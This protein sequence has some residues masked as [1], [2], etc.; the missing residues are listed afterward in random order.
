MG[1]VGLMFG[2]IWFENVLLEIAMYESI[3]FPFTWQLSGF[4]NLEKWAGLQ[5]SSVPLI[6][7][8][9]KIRETKANQAR[10]KQ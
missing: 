3:G 10:N 8:Q 4:A 2:W 5:A 9:L 7:G 1:I 6:Y